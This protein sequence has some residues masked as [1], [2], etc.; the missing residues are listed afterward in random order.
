MSCRCEAAEN[1]QLFLDLT[2]RTQ[3]DHTEARSRLTVAVTVNE[4]GANID[5]VVEAQRQYLFE[6]KQL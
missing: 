5:A 1:L 3:L 2:G 4:L 6:N